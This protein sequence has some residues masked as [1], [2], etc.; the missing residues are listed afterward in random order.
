MRLFQDHYISSEI[1]DL[2]LAQLLAVVL[3]HHPLW[4]SL[5][6]VGV[7]FDDRFVQ[8]VFDRLGV[9]FVVG[10]LDR[11]G[12]FGGQACES[13]TD[14]FDPRLIGMTGTS[15]GCTADCSLLIQ[16]LAAAGIAGCRAS[17]CGCALTASARCNDKRKDDEKKKRV[18]EHGRA[19]FALKSLLPS[20]STLNHSIPANGVSV[21]GFFV[22]HC[23]SS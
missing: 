22:N 17:P 3:I 15:S 4:V 9:S 16:S 11:L 8:K 6:G 10:A 13:G 20:S 18:F 23:N 1:G 5:L 19:S 14:Q 12:G 7:G 21:K 2:L